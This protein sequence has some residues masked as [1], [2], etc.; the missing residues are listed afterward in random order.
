MSGPSLNEEV[1]RGSKSLSTDPPVNR[2]KDVRR[3]EPLQ[4][5]EELL[6]VDDGRRSEAR[7]GRNPSRFHLVNHGHHVPG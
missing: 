1:P 6:L 7:V 4:R 2:T 5:Y 3:G